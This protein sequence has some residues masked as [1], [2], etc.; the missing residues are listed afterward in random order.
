MWLFH[1]SHLTWFELVMT[2]LTCFQCLLR[3][4]VLTIACFSG[5]KFYSSHKCLV[6]QTS[7]MRNPHSNPIC[8]PKSFSSRPEWSLYSGDSIMNVI[9]FYSSRI[10]WPHVTKQKNR[11]PNSKLNRKYQNTWTKP[12]PFPVYFVQ[13]FREMFS[14]YTLFCWNVFGESSVEANMAERSLTEAQ[15]ISDVWSMFHEFSRDVKQDCFP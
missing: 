7:Q 14:N 1:F 15:P 11:L 13:C 3:V 5:S 12:C 10:R 4:P 2:R 9:N 6:Q 8:T